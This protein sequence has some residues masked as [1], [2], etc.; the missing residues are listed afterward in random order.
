MI[1]KSSL[2]L[3]ARIGD[4]IQRIANRRSSDEY[5]RP[6]SVIFKSD[7]EVAEDDEAAV[8]GQTNRRH[9]RR[10]QR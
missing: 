8:V 5:H 10:G 9:I 4:D 3:E 1:G 7:G 2:L 6:G